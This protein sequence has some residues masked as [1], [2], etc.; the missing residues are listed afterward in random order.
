[1]RKIIRDFVISWYSTVSTESSFE[2]EVQ[3]AMISM[4]M[5]LKL[6]A[7]HIDRKVRSFNN[8]RYILI[9]EIIHTQ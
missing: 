6:R 7:K 2:L 5:T 1:M 9:L 3:E 4:A 8:I